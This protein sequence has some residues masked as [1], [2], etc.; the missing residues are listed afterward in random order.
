MSHASGFREYLVGRSWSR[1][2]WGPRHAPA[3]R[4]LARACA[5]VP[6]RA[7]G[8][9]HH[10]VCGIVPRG[11]TSQAG[12][13]VWVSSAAGAVGSLA[14][15]IAKLRGHFVIGSTGPMRRSRTSLDE[16]HLDAA[17]NYHDGPLD[18]C[19]ADA[20][21]DGIDVYFDNVGGDHLEAA[22]GALRRWGRVALCG[23]ISEY[24]GI[25]TRT[26]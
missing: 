11:A 18:D 21:P 23:A 12:D 5:H 2:T 25:P 6:R 3:P 9:W 4:H 13:I 14:A 17:F 16:L 7:G 26:Q 24:Q 22:L 15:Q 8:K 10:R 19:C 1:G 20:A